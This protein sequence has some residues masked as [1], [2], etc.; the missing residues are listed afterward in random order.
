[1]YEVK[2][3]PEKSLFYTYINEI[4]EAFVIKEMLRYDYYLI[5]NKR[6]GTGEYDIRLV[7]CFS[8]ASDAKIY[9]E[10]LSNK[11]LDKGYNVINKHFNRYISINVSIN[12]VNKVIG[13]NLSYLINK[14]I[15]MINSSNGSFKERL[16]DRLKEI[17]RLLE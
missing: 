14:V 2:Y 9:T 7:G 17:K 16:E 11:G 6:F 15:D 1:V 10:F 13:N 8:K 4:D 3:E 5:N 12:R